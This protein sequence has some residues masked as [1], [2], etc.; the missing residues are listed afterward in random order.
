MAR[1]IQ[2]ELSLGVAPD[3]RRI[4]SETNLLYR[5][6]PQV[7]MSTES[8]YGLG[9]IVAQKKGLDI[10][11]HTGG[12]MGFATFLAF[13][14]SKRVGVVM[15]SNGVATVGLHSAL[16][17]RLLELWFGTN[18]K[19]KES[20]DFRIAE[21]KKAL[22]QLRQ[23]LKPVPPEWASSLCGTFFTEEI[24][25]VTIAS[26]KGNLVFRTSSYSTR[27]RAHDRPDGK[28]ALIFID[29]PLAGLE[30]LLLDGTEGA[31]EMDRAQERYVFKPIAPH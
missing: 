17:A 16:W 27:L 6:Q 15:L 12:T 5:R 18:E 2:M 1:Y 21:E 3:G 25:R 13:I 28:R 22:E 4:V 23:R 26:E 7:K 30:I 10:V 14:P 20:L 8:A 11:S 31:F 9:W 29:P 24:G 19:A